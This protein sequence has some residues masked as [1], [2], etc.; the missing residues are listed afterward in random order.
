MAVGGAAYLVSKAITNARVVGFGDLGMEA[1]YEFE[2][3]DM[4]VTVAVDAVGNAVHTIGPCEWCAR[5][6]RSRRASR[7]CR[8]C[9][10]WL[11]PTQLTVIEPRPVGQQPGRQQADSHCQC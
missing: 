4:S 1:I 5:T 3:K 7:T 6:G 2:V 9:R 11:R 8:S 10:P